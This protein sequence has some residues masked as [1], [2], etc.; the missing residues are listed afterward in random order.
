METQRNELFDQHVGMLNESIQIAA[1]IQG[2]LGEHTTDETF[3]TKVII[4]IFLII[5]LVLDL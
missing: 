2:Q 4:S 1:D 3:N 5:Y